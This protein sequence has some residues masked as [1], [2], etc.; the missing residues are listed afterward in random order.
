MQGPLLGRRAAL[1]ILGYGIFL[2]LPAGWSGFVVTDD[3]LNHLIM[4][5]HFVDQ[6]WA[7]DFYPRWM[8]NMNAGLGSPVF[9]F[10]GPVPYYITALFRPL[11]S[12]DPEGWHQLGLA[13]ALAV[14]ASGFTAHAWLRQLA[15][16][17]AALVGAVLYMSAPYH[18]AVDLYQRFFFAE[19][20]G[21][22]W[23]PLVMLFAR[24]SMRGG[25]GA[26][27]GLSLSYALLIMTHLPTTLLFS[28]VPLAYALWQ[29]RPDERRGAFI[30]VAGGMLLGIGLAA[31]YLAPALLTQQ[32]VRFGELKSRFY[33]YAYHFLFFGPRLDNPSLN[34]YLAYLGAIASVMLL[35]SFVAWRSGRATQPAEARREATFWMGVAGVCFFMQLVLSKPVW[36]AVA[37]LQTV[38]FPGRFNTV[39]TLAM[40]LLTALWIDSKKLPGDRA[41]LWIIVGLLVL[42]HSLPVLKGYPRYE[43]WSASPS[44]VGLISSAHRAMEHSKPGADPELERASVLLE[45]ARISRYNFFLPTW[46]NPELFADTAEAV[47]ALEKLASRPDK[48]WRVAGTGSVLVTHWQAPRIELLADAQTP[49]KIEVLQLYYPGWVAR[50]DEG[51]TR[52]EAS[53]SRPQGV[54]AV[55]VP[56]G[57]HRVRI[58]REFLPEERAGQ[59]ISGASL[60]LLTL[61]GMLAAWRRR[62]AGGMP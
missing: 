48:A 43:T 58:E 60:V 57:A 47:R 31:I 52:L 27:A 25:K 20:W 9:Q 24:A 10:Y 49:M 17:R 3:S 22:A 28:W 26:L 46:S 11:L 56:P 23:M 7:G 45:A 8:S 38:Q 16:E 19:L 21:F 53:P 54:L 62:L 15:G 6:L 61:L 44:L 4:S 12:H 13:A 30:R 5:R 50:L 55:Q 29:A 32:H 34:Q 1:I 41:A 14:V 2:T 51:A 36:E 35:V 59:L 42:L 33:D 39:F 40:A 37:I 18:L